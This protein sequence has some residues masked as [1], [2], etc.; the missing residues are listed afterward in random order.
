MPLIKGTSKK[1]IS[2][3]IKTEKAHGKPHKVAVAVA[4]SKALGKRKKKG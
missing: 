4:L 1:V 2:K 3:N